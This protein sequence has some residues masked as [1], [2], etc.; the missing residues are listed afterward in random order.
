[1]LV[2]IAIVLLPLPLLGP[3]LD[4]QKKSTEQAVAAQKQYKR[5]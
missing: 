3:S 1:M 5:P 4:F 2:V